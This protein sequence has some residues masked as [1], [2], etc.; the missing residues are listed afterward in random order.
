MN[1]RAELVFCDPP[2]EIAAPLSRRA[3]RRAAQE[4]DEL[5]LLAAQL[6]SQGV[7][8]TPISRLHCY[9]GP[10]ERFW[11]LGRLFQLAAQAIGPV[12]GTVVGAWLGARSG[13][14]VRLQVGDIEA[15]AHTAE[16]LDALLVRAQQIKQASEPKL[17]NER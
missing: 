8:I 1:D 14:K 4:P 3:R 2:N 16:E 5:S 15:E 17:I 11:E 7:S 12:V 13:R 9:L 10:P 6:R